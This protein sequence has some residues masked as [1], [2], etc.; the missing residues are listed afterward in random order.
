M[1]C[2]WSSVVQQFILSGTGCSYLLL[3]IYPVLQ[4]KDYFPSMK[5]WAWNNNAYNLFC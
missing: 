1:L 3:A 4:F 5:F 2:L